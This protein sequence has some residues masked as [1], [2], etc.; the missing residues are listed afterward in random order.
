LN[1]SC[2]AANTVYSQTESLFIPKHY[3]ATKPSADVDEAFSKE[4]GSAKNVTL[5]GNKIS[6]HRKCLC[7]FE[8]LKAICYKAVL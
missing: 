3:F 5:T 7:V 6:G 8:K 2:A 1:K 4:L